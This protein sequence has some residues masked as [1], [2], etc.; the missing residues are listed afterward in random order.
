MTTQATPLADFIK[1]INMNGMEGRILVLPA[2]RKNQ[3]EILLLYGLHA[4]IERMQGIAEELNKYGRVTLPDLPGHG[5]MDS[6]YTIGEK[7][8]LDNMADYLAAFIK[9]RYRRKRLT[10]IATSFSFIIVTRMLQRNPEIAKKVDVVVSIVGFVHKDD[11]TFS[12]TT[13]YGYKM[14]TWFFSHRIPAAFAQHI[15]LRGP[16]IRAFYNSVAEKHAKLYDGTPEERKRR[17]DFEVVLWQAND[18]RTYMHN[19]TTMLKVDLCTQQ[20]DLPVWH[21]AVEPDQFFNNTY[22]EQHLNVIYSDVTVIHNKT[23]AH[24]PTII[25]TAKD[26]APF[27]PTKLRRMLARK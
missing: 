21:V 23:T 20:V 4:S 2:K 16:F 9:M 22:V 5:G 11:F 19:V 27:I 12:R 6:F 8:T 17:I 10:I 24:A 25:A 1:P 14:G 3:R 18:I 7:P 26:A 13:F 15:A